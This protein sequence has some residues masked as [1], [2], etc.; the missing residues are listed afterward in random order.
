MPEICPNCGLPKEIC[1]CESMAKEEKIRVS[2]TERRFG[3]I[4]TVIT[5]MSRDI[6]L[7]KIARELKTKLAC[8]GTVKNGAIELQGSH[9]ER[10]KQLLIKMG[11]PGDKIEV[12]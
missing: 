12:L 2:T 11:F 1:A 8:G 10:V 6:E 3:K 9:R 5:G 7:R 4:T